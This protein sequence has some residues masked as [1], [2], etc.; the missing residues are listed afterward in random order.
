M[1][2]SPV[3]NSMPVKGG[4]G[5]RP[6][7]YNAE[8]RFLNGQAA[9]SK[10]QLPGLGLLPI[11]LNVAFWNKKKLAPNC[12]PQAWKSNALATPT[13]KDGAESIMPNVALWQDKKLAPNCSFRHEKRSLRHS[14][15]ACQWR[16]ERARGLQ[17]IM[18]NFALWTGKRLAENGSLQVW[19]M[20]LSPFPTASP[21]RTEPVA[22]S[23][24]RARNC[25]KLQR[26]GFKT[27]A[28]SETECQWRRERVH[29]LKPI[30]R[31]VAFWMDKKL[32]PNRSFQAW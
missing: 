14:E 18:L 7:A 8:R 9:S 15:T 16:T 27:V 1:L 24:S 6:A 32:V 28:N 26:P 4:A 17:P 25:S 12:S 19:Q 20:L 31:N 13:M 2:P 23:P 21:W 30:I 22:Y 10:Q 29:G 5:S 11:M 3:Q